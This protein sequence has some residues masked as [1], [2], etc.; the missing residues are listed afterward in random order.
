MLIITVWQRISPEVI[1]RG[2]KKCCMYSATGK[3]D[4]DMLWNSR[5]EDGYLSE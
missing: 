2:F 3:T 1:A 5:K 4:G